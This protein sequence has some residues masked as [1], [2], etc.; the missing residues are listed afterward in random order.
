MV[1]RLHLPPVPRRPRPTHGRDGSPSR[2]GFPRMFRS[3][4]A[5]ARLGAFGFWP[6]SDE[7]ST[8]FGWWLL[9]GEGR[10]RKRLDP[11]THHWFPPMKA[12]LKAPQTA[13]P[14][15]LSLRRHP[16]LAPLPVPSWPVDPVRWERELR[17]PA[18]F[19]RVALERGLTWACRSTQ[20]DERRLMHDPVTERS[21]PP[22]GWMES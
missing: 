17:D 22:K 8:P 1:I 5:S 13:A 2:R 4:G 19:S 16:R 10:A 9:P 6:C 11:V 3:G 12:S 18:G 20:A 21:G 7:T 15:R 14:G